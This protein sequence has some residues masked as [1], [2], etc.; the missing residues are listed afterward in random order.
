MIK[1]IYHIFFVIYIFI[2][3]LVYSPDLPLSRQRLDVI[4]YLYIIN[5]C[6]RKIVSLID[7]LGNIKIIS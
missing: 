6:L 3:L 2:I 5:L 1:K 7:A 4:N